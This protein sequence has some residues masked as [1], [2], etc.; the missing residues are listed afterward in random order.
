MLCEDLEPQQA[1]LVAQRLRAAAAQ[2]FT[3]HGQPIQLTAA[4]GIST[5]IGQPSTK[6]PATLLQRADQHMYQ[7]ERAHPT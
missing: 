1:E 7:A 6:D 2:P 5:S 4:V 3:V